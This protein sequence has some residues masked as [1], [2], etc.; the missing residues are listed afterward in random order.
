MKKCFLMGHRDS[1][2][3]LLPK[4]TE[5]IRQCIEEEN[6]TDFFVGS[7]GNFDH[8]CVQT[9]KQIKLLYPKIHLYLLTPYYCPHSTSPRPDEFEG[10][11]F[12]EGM[13]SVPPKFA[14]SRLN[15]I[16]VKECDYLITF[17]TRTSSPL[18]PIYQSALS[19]Q[20]KRKLII[21]NLGVFPDK[22]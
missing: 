22:E 17:L 13:E 20:K 11:Y 8:M 15:C 7:R 6:I 21:K 18:Y 12:P 19:Q 2:V 1:P 14:I 10:T 9:L 5:A 3:T 4:L 16:M